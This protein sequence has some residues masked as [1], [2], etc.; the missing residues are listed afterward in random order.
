MSGG[1]FNY[2]EMHLE[3]MVVPSSTMSLFYNLDTITEL[4]SVLKQRLWQ[5]FDQ[6]FGEFLTC[7]LVK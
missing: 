5:V 7:I 4:A 3:G 6:D 2:H 1:T